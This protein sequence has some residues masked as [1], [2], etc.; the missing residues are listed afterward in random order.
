LDYLIKEFI[1]TDLS[2]YDSC[3][4]ISICTYGNHAFLLVNDN[5]ICDPWANSVGDLAMSPYAG[6][7]LE[8]YFGIRSDWT[9]YDSNK[10][11]VESTKYTFSLFAPQRNIYLKDDAISA[12]S[13]KL[14]TQDD[15]SQ[16]N[17][18]LF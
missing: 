5:I 15:E 14:V 1:T 10:S 7:K 4:P 3:I 8:T 6:L 17:K 12:V 9:C 16:S 11:D 18:H 2:T 13:E